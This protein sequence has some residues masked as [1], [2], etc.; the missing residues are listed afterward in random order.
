MERVAG[1]GLAA[2]EVDPIEV[3]VA[4]VVVSVVAAVASVEVLRRP[5]GTGEWVRLADRRHPP[6]PTV[7]DPLEECARASCLE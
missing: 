4:V 7:Y 3:V 5:D 1:D 2:A 6:P